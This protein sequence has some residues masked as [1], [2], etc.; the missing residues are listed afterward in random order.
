MTFE[1]CC[2]QDTLK[3][4]SNQTETT[5]SKSWRTNIR[6]IRCGRDCIE[7]LAHQHSTDTMWARPHQNPG[8]PTFDGYDVGAAAFQK[9]R[10]RRA[11]GTRR[12]PEKCATCHVETSALKHSTI[13]QRLLRQPKASMK[14]EDKENEVQSSAN[15][16]EVKAKAKLGE[17]EVETG[18]A[19]EGEVET[20]EDDEESTCIHCGRTDDCYWKQYETE[21]REEG[22]L[23]VEASNK[24]I[25]F[26]LYR[27]V[28]Q[29]IHGHLG[30]GNRRPTPG[31]V[32]IKVKELWPE[33]HERDYVG[34]QPAQKRFKGG[35]ALV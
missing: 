11:Q 5:A 35:S 23:M 18:T 19:T 22:E 4:T 30:T 2:L 13:T 26:K 17:S 3:F 28:I 1:L 7:I 15:N 33:A 9:G 31:C 29:Q 21:L 6:Q 10:I 20:E 16:A 14:Q 25:R 32:H 12:V 8:A 24:E 27:M 34:Y